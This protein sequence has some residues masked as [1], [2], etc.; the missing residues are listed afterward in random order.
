MELNNLIN[1]A[2]IL[3]FMRT[4][5]VGRGPTLPNI[6]RTVSFG[7][8]VEQK[9]GYLNTCLWEKGNRLGS[10]F[11]FSGSNWNSCIDEIVDH[12][13]NL[14]T[15]GNNLDPSS[16]HIWKWSTIYLTIP[17]LPENWDPSLFPF[18]QR[19]VLQHPPFDSSLTLAYSRQIWSN[20]F[21]IKRVQAINVTQVMFMIS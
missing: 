21:S 7:G 14:G 11:T 13:R 3:L 16:F 17:V 4:F 19:H 10:Q 6:G 12:L 18:S 1:I 15:T 2:I 20:H 5:I 9:E 8:R